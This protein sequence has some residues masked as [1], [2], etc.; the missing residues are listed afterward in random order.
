MTKYQRNC[1]YCGTPQERD[2]PTGDVVCYECKELKIRLRIIEKE[3]KEIHK[4]LSLFPQKPYSFQSYVYYI[5]ILG[6]HVLGISKK[7]LERFKIKKQT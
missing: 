6:H 1:K 5:S 2:K 3:G 4:H 7:G